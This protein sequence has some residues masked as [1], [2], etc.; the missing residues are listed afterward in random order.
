MRATPDSRPRTKR[1]PA[2][3]ASPPGEA[4][5][6]GATMDDLHALGLSTTQARRVV[7][8][9]DELG[10]VATLDDLD[11]VPGIPARLRAEAKE[12]LRARE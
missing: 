3:P 2:A 4:T 1:S 5:L 10:L 8:Y 12:R 9:R 7:R 6:A 11:Q